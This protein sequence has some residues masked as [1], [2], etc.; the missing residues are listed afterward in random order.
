MAIE[1]FGQWKVREIGLRFNRYFVLR[2][3]MCLQPCI[4]GSLLFE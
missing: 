1:I 4:S 2:N 3:A